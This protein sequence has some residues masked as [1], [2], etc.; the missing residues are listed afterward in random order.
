MM[1]GGTGRQPAKLQTSPT[2]TKSVARSSD[3]GSITVTGAVNGH[4]QRLLVD[5]GS[6][7]T[8][9]RSDLVEA[10][11]IP[12]THVDLCGVTGHRIPLRGPVDVELQ[13]GTASMRHFVYVADVA[14]PCILGLD[15]LNKYHC[16]I[17]IPNL[18]ME[19]AGVQV[20]LQ[21][22]DEHDV[23]S[24]RVTTQHRI[25]I[26]PMSET[27]V[28]CH[29][30][31]L[32]KHS[33]LPVIIEG[34]EDTMDRGLVVGRTLTDCGKEAMHVLV[35]NISDR[36]ISLPKGTLLGTGETVTH[37]EELKEMP[38]DRSEHAQ[39]LPE[40]LQDLYKQSCSEL[41]PEEAHELRHLLINYADVF[42]KGNDDLGCT[43]LTEHTVETGDHRP[44]K[45][46]PRKV[47][48]GKRDEAEKMIQDMERQGLIEPS[49]SPWSFPVVMVK[50][51]DGTLRFCV[52]Y[53]ALNH[54]T[55]KD[56]YPLPRIDD[57]LDALSGSKWFSTLDLKSGYHQVKMADEDKEK[58][59]FCAGGGLKTWQFRVM[60]FGLCNAPATFERLMERVLDGL[61]WKASL[62]YLDDVIV[63]GRTF[64]EQ[65][66]HLEAVFKRLLHVG[67]K[68]SP[69]KCNL[70]Q[71]QV[72]YLGHVVSHDGVTADPEKTRAVEE[73]PVPRDQHQLRSFLGLCS[74]YRRFVR[75]FALIA[76]PLHHLTKKAQRFNWTDECQQAFD[77][78]KQHLIAAPILAYPNASD[79]FVLDTDASNCSIGG[80]LSQVH[81]G[82]EHVI[83]YFSRSLN[84]AERNYCVTRRELLSIVDSIK[85]FH[86]Y[87][88]GKH[89]VM[90][91]DHAALQWLRRLKEPEGQLARWIARIDQ[92]DYEIQ[93]RPGRVHN[94]AD[95]LSRRPCQSNCKYCAP[96]EVTIDLNCRQISMSNRRQG[97]RGE[98]G[99][100]KGAQSVE[101]GA[102][103]THQ[104]SDVD[105]QLDI[106]AEDP[107]SSI[108]EERMRQAQL[109]DPDIGPIIRH[110]ED[111]PVRPNWDQ[112]SAL[113]PEAKG[114]WARWDAMKVHNGILLHKWES[115]DGLTV[116]WQVV[117]PRQLRSK[118]LE[119]QHNNITS[120]HLGT[121]KTLGRLR[122]RFFWL[123]MRGDVK[124][125]CRSCSVCCAKKGPKRRPNAPLQIYTAGAPMERVAVDIAGPL[126]VTSAGNRY[127]CVAMDYFTK[128]P[129]AYPIPNQEATT[130][131]RVLVEQFFSRFGVPFE[132]HSD[133]GR[134]FEA[135][136]FKEC[137]DLLGI[138]KTRTTPLRPQS[139]GMVEKFN[140]TL[141]Q[142]LAK[143]CTEKQDDWDEK[144][145]LLLMAYRSAEHEVT[146]YSPAQMM[147]GHELRLP[148]DLIISRPPDDDLPT[149]SAT[150]VRKLKERLDDVHRVVR[151]RLK[152]AADAMK[153][154]HD[155]KATDVKFD[156]GE[157]VWFY[158]PRR[159]KG[160]CPKLMSDWDGPYEVIHRL[161]DVTYRIKKGTRAKPKVVHANR[162]W[163]CHDPSFTWENLSGGNRPDF[164]LR[165]DHVGHEESTGDSRDRATADAGTSQ[166]PDPTA[167]QE[168][169]PQCPYFLRPRRIPDS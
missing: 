84:S 134:N 162:L 39:S 85:H 92:Y 36:S 98:R 161:S 104:V 46:P 55:V 71:R 166:F 40:H 109:A 116:H 132:L 20:E 42:S 114:L 140:W 102:R 121:K 27:I 157:A 148:V 95:A 76:A 79:S 37:V 117:I 86:H 160:K 149:D 107:S 50:K 123:G 142:E 73:W 101:S 103:A 133:Q 87:L 48:L 70:F 25:R 118:I 18:T 69:K 81:D 129:E 120:G 130:V 72:K 44:I 62:V 167:P 11:E 147:M 155:A 9:V 43:D 119:E 135:S 90:R 7:K 66:S 59:A 105:E 33:T 54:I 38:L 152:I 156:V 83:A 67:L 10:K 163:K 32:E 17:D 41:T 77:T 169:L 24:Y 125:W 99:E 65:S 146:D 106:H 78:L 26:P 159:M 45:L 12:E 16:S 6:N 47:P 74:Y 30:E 145:P 29:A 31:G 34:S 139:D 131:A 5:T 68:L 52:D 144:L 61:N 19:A 168:P 91:S 2:I 89:F 94:N 165:G 63:L 82:Q 110:M 111:S 8:I 56:S 151:R 127:I 1:A 112:V 60:P 164:E 124:E 97:H 14:D 35:A 126:P 150:F 21:L 75:D 113:G 154:R 158:N 22:Q 28:Q 57:T 93:Y 122:N 49:K 51:K 53:R 15:F 88:Y 80:V 13:V 153:T 141:G 136:V 100:E 64:Q 137:C 143:F 58:T 128:W 23:S 115:N 108:S 4:R 3:S 96:K 138:R